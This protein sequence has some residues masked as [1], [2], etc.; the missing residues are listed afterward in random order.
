M[1][2]SR[3][4]ADLVDRWTSPQGRRLQ[5]QVLDWLCGQTSR[6]AGLAETGGR[7]DLRGVPLYLRPATLVGSPDEPVRSVSWEALDLRG[8]QLD[9]FRFFGARVT[10]CLFDG[11]TCHAWRLWGTTI[12]RCSFRRSDLTSSALG[13]NDWQGQINTWI[14]VAFDSAKLNHT[15]F[16][17]A[18]LRRCSFHNLHRTSLQDC[19]V[20][21]CTFSGK[22]AILAIDGRGHQRPVDPAALRADFR[23]ARLVNSMIIG[24]RLNDN[25]LPKQADLLVLHRYPKAIRAA[26]T[27]LS[28][29][30]SPAAS[31]ARG[32]IDYL[33]KAPGQEDS[34]LCLDLD[35]L[36]DETA[37]VL[38]AS[39]PNR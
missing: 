35:S 20:D 19:Q 5:R 37:R 2:S 27:C 8:A 10:D 34:D 18:A 11:A 33:L 38:L 28:G 30:D 21:D 1:S 12:E 26:R 39:L 36:G 23:D 3:A 16:A 17:G 31:R 13:T 15:F 9:S 32:L 4:S 24:Y 14:D 29:S 6:P 7:T 22:L 25:D